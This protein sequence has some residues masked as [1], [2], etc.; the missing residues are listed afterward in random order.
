MKKKAEVAMNLNTEN[1]PAEWPRGQPRDDRAAGCV[2]IMIQRRGVVSL[3]FA[4]SEGFCHV[5]LKWRKGKVH[6]Q[7]RCLDVHM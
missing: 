5:C 7:F 3:A 4:R 1:L 2:K 6:K